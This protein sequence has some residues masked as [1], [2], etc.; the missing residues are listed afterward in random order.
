MKFTIKEK[1]KKDI[2]IS[3]FNVLKNCSS[4]INIM[5]LEDHFYVQGMDRSHVCLFDLKIMSPW[6]ESY[7]KKPTESGTVC[8]D[9]HIFHQIL[10]FAQE[11]DTIVFEYN[12]D[13]DNTS[14]QMLNTDNIKGEFN[15][16]FKIPLTEMNCDLLSIPEVEYDVEF[17]IKAK[18]MNEIVSQL[19]VFGETIKIESSET[20]IK[21]SSDGVT[22]NM[23]VSIPIDDLNDYAVVEGETVNIFFSLNYIQKMCLTTKLS[24]EIEFFISKEY[25]MKI[26]YDLGENSRF[27]FYIAPKM[28]D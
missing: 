3:L 26:K 5:F 20:E 12:I 24:Q 1:S 19:S 13:E 25:P 11:K 9:S 2:F 14:I 10:S 4:L 8:V 17:S 6:F 27:M 16:F 23:M 7:E 22:G 15:K 18:K 28:D 21:M